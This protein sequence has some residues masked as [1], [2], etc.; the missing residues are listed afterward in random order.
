MHR[1][2]QTF[3]QEG[4]YVE[5]GRI[6]VDNSEFSTFSTAF[7]TR[8][9]HSRCNV[10]IY[11]SGSHKSKR[12]PSAKFPLFRR[13]WFLPQGVIC[14]ENQDLTRGATVGN[15][16]CTGSIVECILIALESV[17]CMRK[18]YSCKMFWRLPNILP[19]RVAQE[20][21]ENSVISN[22]RPAPAVLPVKKFEKGG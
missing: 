3:P 11:T 19:I 17:L 13:L 12:Q 8:V 9:F 1:S 5:R 21:N 7:S 18:P 4:R 10:W 6:S 22:E 20:E 14:A 2:M 15:S 16:L